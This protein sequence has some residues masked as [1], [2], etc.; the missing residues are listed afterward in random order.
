MFPRLRSPIAD[1]LTRKRT[2]GLIKLHVALVSKKQGQQRN[3]TYGS[4]EGLSNESCPR[5]ELYL[6]SN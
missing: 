2:A 5:V 3:A 1:N 6:V 4:E